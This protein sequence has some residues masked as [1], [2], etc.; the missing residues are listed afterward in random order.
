MLIFYILAKFCQIWVKL[1]MSKI[2]KIKR[3]VLISLGFALAT[4]LL[5]NGFALLDQESTTSKVH[6]NAVK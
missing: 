3:V 4:Y 2:Q 5:L 1:Y 6:S